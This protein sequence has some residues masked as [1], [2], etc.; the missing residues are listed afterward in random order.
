MENRF[1][2]RKS[3]SLDVMVDHQGVGLVN[4]QT[5]NISMGG[6]YID[7]GRIRLPSNSS[8]KI[9]F[10]LNIECNNQTHDISGIVV[11]SKEDGVGIMFDGM[12]DDCNAALFSMIHGE[13]NRSTNGRKPHSKIST[14]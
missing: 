13:H 11:R 1:N 12:S 7:T 14:F 2:Q 5:I 3:I 4:A 6:M 8:I 10:S 9:F